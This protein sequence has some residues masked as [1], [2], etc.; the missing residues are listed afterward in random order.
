[1]EI[2]CFEKYYNSARDFKNSSYTTYQVTREDIMKEIDIE[3]WTRAF[4]IGQ[5]RDFMAA[6]KRNE[7]LNQINDRK[8]PSFEEETVIETFKQLYAGLNKIFAEKVDGVFRNLS[9]EH[10]TNQPEGFCKRM[11]FKIYSYGHDYYNHLADLIQCVH[12]IVNKHI[13]IAEAM[14]SAN[15]IIYNQPCDGKWYPIAGEWIKCRR[16]MNG[17]THVEVHPDIAWQLN[18]VLASY[19][20]NTLAI[21]EKFRKPQKQRKVKPLDLENTYISPKVLFMLAKAYPDYAKKTYEGIY[22]CETRSFER[23][24]LVKSVMKRIGGKENNHPM[25]SFTFDYDPSPILDLIL[26]KGVIPDYVS[27]QFY[28]TPKEI[29]AEMLSGIDSYQDISNVLEPSGGIGNLVCTLF[30][31]VGE[32]KANSLNVD[33]VEI[34]EFN[35]SVLKERFA[36]HSNVSVKQEDFL[37]FKNKKAYDLIIMNPPFTGNQCA[38]HID[39]ALTML[40]S[41]GILKAVVPSGFNKTLSVPYTLSEKEYTGFD[42]TG[43]SVRILTVV[44]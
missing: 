35:C 7:W 3:Y 12:T 8:V 20:Q 4:N 42:N 22:I 44:K 24:S 33:I 15:A 5:L 25:Y 36:K 29:S 39:K 2:T 27:H 23:F 21:P 37:S 41:K 10:V 11:I 43:I 31:T 34:S 18:K 1:M 32:E 13:D 9:K 38:A 28:P 40:S 17:N 14:R 26:E 19:G 16:Y 30:D 6:D